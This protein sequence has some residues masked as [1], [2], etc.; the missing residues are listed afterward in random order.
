MRNEAHDGTEGQNR[1][2]YTDNQNRKN[3]GDYTDTEKWDQAEHEVLD[4][5]TTATILSV[6][7]VAEL[8]TEEFNNAICDKYNEID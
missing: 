2:S 6:Q 5:L 3:Y 7:G 8:V 4:G 1:E